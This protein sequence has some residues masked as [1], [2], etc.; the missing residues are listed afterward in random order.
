MDTNQVKS[1]GNL[2]VGLSRDAL[3]K[4]SK[5]AFLS[6]VHKIAI[7]PGMTNDKFE[8]LVK[9]GKKYYGKRYV[10]KST[11][12]YRNTIYNTSHRNLCCL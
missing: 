9:L 7:K 10:V 11:M 4:L 12:V 2:I 8:E 3:S 5:N 6:E 1:L